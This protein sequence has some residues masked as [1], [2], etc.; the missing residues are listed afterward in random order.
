MSKLVKLS[1]STSEVDDALAKNSRAVVTNSL[2]SAILSFF[3][4]LS[5]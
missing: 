5:V 4:E 2:L 1:V 3:E